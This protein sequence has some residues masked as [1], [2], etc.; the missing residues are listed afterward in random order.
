MSKRFLFLLLLSITV[1]TAC[2]EEIVDKENSEESPLME[3]EQTEAQERSLTTIELIEKLENSKYVFVDIR[4]QAEYIGWE[5]NGEVRGGHIKGAVN[6]PLSWTK[7]SEDIK[8]LLLQKG[9]T[10]EKN[11]IVYDALGNDVQEM[12]TVLTSLGYT[13]VDVYTEGLVSW[14]ADQNLPIEH[15]ANYEKLTHP[16]WLNELI[17]G[18]DPETYNNEEFKIFEVAWGEPKDYNEGHIPGAYYLDTNEI[19]EEPLWNRKSDQDIEKMLLNSGITF[20]T[21]VILYGRDNMAAARAASIMLYAGVEDVRLLDGGY[22]AWVN[23]GYDFD[24]TPN[25]PKPVAH[26][27]VEVPARPDYIIDT[28][29]AKECLINDNAKLVDI[30]SWPEYIGETSGYTYIIPKGRII[31]SEWGYAGSDAYNM[32][33]YRNIDNTMRSY[34]EIAQNW[35]D[36]GI[37]EDQEVSFYCGTSWRASEAFFAAYLMGWENI[38]VYDGGWF[39]WSLDEENPIGIGEPRN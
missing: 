19:E 2:N 15:L 26:F 13:N 23:A 22:N 33:D 25:I 8:E 14:A 6:F 30:R 4:S 39:E 17:E 27:G 1:L 28:E 24:T 21:T 5:M 36:F 9:I 35:S 16:T 32:E 31:G 20:D 11:V 10:A 37:T 29:E 12:V 3:T 34:H 7:E 38:S 18:N